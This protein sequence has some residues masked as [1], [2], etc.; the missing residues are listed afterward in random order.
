[1]TFLKHQF[2]NCGAWVILTAMLTW[3]RKQ[4]KFLC[5]PRLLSKCGNKQL[6]RRLPPMCNQA[7]LAAAQSRNSQ[8]LHCTQHTGKD[9]ADFRGSTSNFSTGKQGKKEPGSPAG[10]QGTGLQMQF[11][12]D[13]IVGG[14]WNTS[15]WGCHKRNMRL[16]VWK[17]EEMDAYLPWGW[18]PE[19]R[20]LLPPARCCWGC[21]SLGYKT[22]CQTLQQ[23]KTGDILHFTSKCRYQI[24]DKKGKLIIY[25]LVAIKHPIRDSFNCPNFT[26]IC[27]NTWRCHSAWANLNR[28]K[29]RWTSHTW[30]R[31]T[32]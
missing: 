15:L 22:H 29:H 28:L 4:H 11:M 32:P 6:K 2:P 25:F 18:L 3:G 12:E 13:R 17:D 26:W 24:I 23:N 30:T 8:P 19:G 9:P 27:T 14:S 5:M 16:G 21:K 1:M 20:E 10:R 7:G 31:Q